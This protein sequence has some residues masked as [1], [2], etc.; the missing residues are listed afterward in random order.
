M[1]KGSIADDTLSQQYS[2][3]VTDNDGN[4]TRK[5]VTAMLV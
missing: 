5:E 4:L 3:R 2:I 1:L